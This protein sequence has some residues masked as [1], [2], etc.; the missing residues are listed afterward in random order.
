MNRDAIEREAG[1]GE[2]IE[3][4]L[5]DFD[6]P[7]EPALERPLESRAG[8]NPRQE[9]CG[10]AGDDQS[11]RDPGAYQQQHSSDEQPFS[12]VFL[13]PPASDLAIFR[14]AS[15]SSMSASTPASSTST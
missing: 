14:Y 3:V 4:D 2:Q 1:A 10:I 6:P 7:A 13:S 11:E 12:S 5:P 15:G 8:R 9:T